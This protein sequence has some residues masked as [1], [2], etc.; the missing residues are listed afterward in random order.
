[1][2]NLISYGVSVFCQYGLD[3]S[4]V[5]GLK[6]DLRNRLRKKGVG[7][8]KAALKY[9]FLQTQPIQHAGFLP[10]RAYS[11]KERVTRKEHDKPIWDESDE[12]RQDLTQ[13]IHLNNGTISTGPKGGIHARTTLGSRCCWCL[14][15]KEF[16]VGPRDTT[17]VF[18]FSA[19][20][21]CPQEKNDSF[22]SER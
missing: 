16:P 11:V 15:S 14:N 19:G 17:K 13:F 22:S 9:H 10:F 5:L 4:S 18:K 8:T 6:V 7:E 20:M 12:V 2:T 1:M 3:A 21:T